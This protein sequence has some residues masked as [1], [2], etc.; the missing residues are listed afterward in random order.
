MVIEMLYVLH[1][2]GDLAINS[3]AKF[4]GEG[5]PVVSGTLI[6]CQIIKRNYESIKQMVCVLSQHN[7]QEYCC[8]THLS[9]RISIKEPAGRRCQDINNAGT[10]KYLYRQP[11]PYYR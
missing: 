8:N 1:V 4:C 10:T 11:E 7:Q 5:T 3:P 6:N 9:S 2:L